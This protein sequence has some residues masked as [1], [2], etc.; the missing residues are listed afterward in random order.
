MDQPRESPS[1]EAEARFNAPPPGP[2]G[3][4]A[5]SSQGAPA[6]SEPAPKPEPHADEGPV[7][8]GV[9]AGSASEYDQDNSGDHLLEA[10]NAD[11][12][13]SDEGY[14]QPPFHRVV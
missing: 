9:D 8:S 11:D 5:G 1:P 3:H 2:S 4:D 7:D 10:H 14:A 6:S 12:S 13:F